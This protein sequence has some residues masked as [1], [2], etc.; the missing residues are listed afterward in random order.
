MGEGPGGGLSNCS[1]KVERHFASDLSEM[2]N[3]VSHANCVTLN[4]ENFLGY[5]TF[6]SYLEKFQ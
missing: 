1:G 5:V 6:S 4:T 2:I 3:I